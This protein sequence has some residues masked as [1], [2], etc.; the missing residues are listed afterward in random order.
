MGVQ[1]GTVMHLL[2]FSLLWAAA[3][4]SGKRRIAKA[5]FK[6]FPHHPLVA[7]W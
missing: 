1:V 4:R 6:L 7:R 2:V 3:A 5:P